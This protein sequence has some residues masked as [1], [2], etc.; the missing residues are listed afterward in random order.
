MKTPM[1]VSMVADAFDTATRNVPAG[2]IIDA[3]RQGKWQTQ[4]E[5]IRR[6]YAKTIL[7]TDDAKAAKDAVESFKKKL[8]GILVS[9][10]FK[11]RK[12]DALIQH[13]GL[14]C[15]D[16]DDLD[17]EKLKDAAKKLKQSPYLLAEF[18][19]PTRGLKAFFRVPADADKHAGSFRAVEKHVRD[20]TGIE[21]DQSG[22]DLARM[23]FVSY[24]PDCY[25]NP[26]AREIE[27]LP[28]PLR[29]KVKPAVRTRSDGSKPDKKQICEMLTFIP[30]RPDYHDW[31]KVVS[32]VGDALADNE[33][34]EV[35]NEWSPEE[36]PGEYADKLRHRLNEV[37]IGTLIRLAREH[38]WTG[39]L[40]PASAPETRSHI[41][42]GNVEPVELSPPPAPYTPPPLSLLPSQ[43]QDYIHAAAAALNVDVAFILLPILSSLGT[44]IGN[45]RSIFLKR[46]FIQPPVIW[47][48]IIGRSG[49]RKSPAL[50]ASC[51]GIME[52][53]QELMLQN[54]EAFELYVEELSQWKSK[55]AQ[56]RGPEP[57]EPSILTCVCDDLTIE[58]L[59]DRL[60]ANPRGL[61]V[62]KD[63]LSHWL[64]SFDQYRNKNAKGSDVSRWLSVHTGV[65]LAVDR[66]KDNLHHRIWQPRVCITGAIQPQIL[67]RLLT[68]EYFERGLPA[69]LLFAYPPFRQ[70]RWSEATVP[71]D[72]RDAVLNL[73]E[74]L[75]LLQAERDEHH[76]PRPKLLALDVEAK[77]VFI[78]FY[79]A[80]GNASVEAGEH[81]EAAWNKLTGYGARLALVGQ[82]AHD[83]NAEIVIGN[84]MQ[85]ACELARWFG[86][87]AVR[88][89]AE[90]AERP[91]QRELR[92]VCEWV[93]R[94]GGTATLRDTITY[95][96]TLKNKPEKAQR[97]YEQ[98][99]KS[100]RGKW[101]DRQ[102]SGRGRPTR[103]FRLL[104]TSASA[105]IAK[106]REKRANCADALNSQK[107]SRVV[108]PDAE[109]VSG[110]LAAMPTGVLEL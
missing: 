30:K 64:A 48:V 18:R 68:P 31:I 77:S 87:E 1:I 61:L 14:L 65:F 102:P 43:L 40:R 4:I 96:W 11:Q 53:E 108:E 75:W 8:P 76:Q 12:N 41:T 107:I 55:K 106:L 66:K 74:E 2:K 5:Q 69:R 100:G 15:A 98:L 73:F 84:V 59:A 37:H 95:Y 10:T 21:I 33:A 72:L 90:L 50:E 26:Y 6:L 78:D 44:A 22:K 19:S 36:Q 92:E 38:G 57:E 45:A 70:D 27:P 42:T 35:L 109:A 81:E 25:F 28:E 99:V 7:R 13:S 29:L 105:K 91:E 86:N 46:G 23:C 54:K 47:P 3:I 32:G 24:D 16:L 51:F 20:L 79:N 89:Y 52:R 60:V 39:N 88:I 34:I 104:P 101:E 82:L 58:V 63:E 97:M 93:E 9:G 71:D 83:P 110:E 103:I 67:R 85:S 17:S 49:S 94:R 80:C 56:K 62:R